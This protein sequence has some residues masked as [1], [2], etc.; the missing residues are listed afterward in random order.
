MPLVHGA[1]LTAVVFSLANAALL[2]VRIR[3]EERALGAA[4]GGGLR[5]AAALRPRGL[6]WPLTTRCC[7]EHPAHRAR[8]SSEL[9]GRS[10]R[11]DDLLAG[12]ALDSLALISLA[13]A[14]EDR[15]RVKL[16]ARTTPRRVRTVGDLAPARGASGRT[17][18]AQ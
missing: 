17:E 16:D 10:V 4:L 1:W 6:R 5:A 15:F 8:A 11:E 14:L 9:A 3:A 7:D 2:A 12:S 13:V 18:A